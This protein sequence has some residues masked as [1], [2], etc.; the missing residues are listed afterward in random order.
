MLPDATVTG[1]R[2]IIDWNMKS[3]QSITLYLIAIFKI[4]FQ[5]SMCGELQKKVGIHGQ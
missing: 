1:P 4:Q 2:I 5:I 3:D